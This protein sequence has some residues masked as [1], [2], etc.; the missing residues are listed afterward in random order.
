MAS[1][2]QGDKLEIKTELVLRFLSAANVKKGD[3]GN[4]NEGIS[5]DNCY[6]HCEGGFPPKLLPGCALN[7]LY[8]LSPD[9]C[10]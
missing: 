10:L 5:Y 8:H 1:I 9:I 3:K 7:Y 6:D 4:S 2:R